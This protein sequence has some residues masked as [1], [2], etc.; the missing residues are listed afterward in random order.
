[1]LTQKPTEAPAAAVASKPAARP[2]MRPEGDVECW[3]EG[4]WV[5]LA[6]AK[7]G[8][9]THS[10][11]YGT[12]VFEGI[13]AYWNEEQGQL[14]LLKLREHY[15][16]IIDSGKI[17][18]MDPGYTVQELIDLTVELVR[19]NGFREDTYV[20]PTLYKSSEAIGVRL[21][22]VDCKINILAIPFGDYISTDSGIRCGTVSWRR[23]SD[24][25]IPSRAKIVGSYVNPA[26]SKTE[27]VLNGYDEAI[28]LTHDGKVS[29]GSAE[30][31]FMV[32]RG[33]IV[34]PGVD[35]DILEGITRAGII[36]LA[37]QELGIDVVARTVDRT[38]LYLADEVFLCGTGA[39]ISPVTSIDHRPIGT[40]EVGTH[41]GRHQP[42]LLRCGA[43]QERRVLG[44]A[45]AR[46][47]SSAAGPGQAGLRIGG[48]T[49]PPLRLAGRGLAHD[50]HDVRGLAGVVDLH[51]LHAELPFE[52]LDGHGH[53]RRRAVVGGDDGVRVVVPVGPAGIDRRY[54]AGRGR[55]RPE[56]VREAGR[57]E[58][59][60]TRC[61]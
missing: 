53:A 36:R 16:R 5:R 38:E 26:F 25:S 10:F 30:N 52:R 22:N 27:A 9:M 29:E 41:L 31:L 58:V 47:L 12:A 48:R 45:D 3:F 57:P 43:G 51:R 20:R 17:M 28:V 33:Q 11:L 54:G 40:G 14:Y 59:A 1:M 60:A 8:I 2:G 19:R 34:T 18:L 37:K 23:T 21:H 46:L 50:D 7:V 32:R 42:R 15:E 55:H 4:A 35:N 44:L 6:D 13:R 39:Q 49:R 56:V 61:R 24:L